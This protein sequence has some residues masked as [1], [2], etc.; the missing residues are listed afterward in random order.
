MKVEKRSA[1]NDISTE[2]VQLSSTFIKKGTAIK[3]MNSSSILA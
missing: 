1:L 2:T 3:S